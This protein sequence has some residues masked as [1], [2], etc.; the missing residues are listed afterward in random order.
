MQVSCFIPFLFQFLFSFLLGQGLEE[1]EVAA[2][3][4]MNYISSDKTSVLLG[5]SLKDYSPDTLRQIGK[6]IAK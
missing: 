2:R 1:V 3:Y 5:L 4:L 6:L